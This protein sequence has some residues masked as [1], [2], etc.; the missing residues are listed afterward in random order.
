MSV[1]RTGAI[2]GALKFDVSEFRRAHTDVGEGARSMVTSLLGVGAKA[3]GAAIAIAI[4]TAA[5]AALAA[6]IK[7]AIK[8][9]M[10]FEDSF[11]F[12]RKTVNATAA[13]LDDM[14]KALQDMSL[15]V[16]LS[17]HELNT[18][19]GAAG[20]LGIAKENI[21]DFTRVMSEMGV[22]ADL[23]A[24]QSAVGFAQWANVT[25]LAT[26]K[27][28]NLTS[29][30]VL[31]GNTTATTESMVLNMGVRLAGASR[32][33][34]LADSDI[35][36][37]AATMSSLRIEAE[38]GGSAMSR[39]M[40]DMAEAVDSGGVNLELFAALAK[41]STTD[42]V[43]EFKNKPMQAITEFIGGLGR[44]EQ[45]GQNVTK[46]L[47][48]LGFVDVRVRSALLGMSGSADILADNVKRAAEEF[49]N[50]TARSDEAAKAFDRTSSKVTILSNSTGELMRSIGEGLQPVYE[51]LIDTLTDVV[52]KM[53]DVIDRDDSLR[54]LSALIF[55]PKATG[56]IRGYISELDA[57]SG[58]ADS[59]GKALKKVDPTI[60]KA[61][62]DHVNSANDAF[63]DQ[64]VLVDA[65]TGYFDKYKD[66]AEDVAAVMDKIASKS[67]KKS[68]GSSAAKELALLRRQATGLRL[69]LFPDEAMADAVGN[70]Q[71][72]AD[73]FPDI[74]D[75]DAVAQAMGK[76]WD[77]FKDKG[78]N[79]AE[80]FREHL[81]TAPV[82]FAQAMDLAIQK[83][84]TLAR[85]EEERA[86]QMREMERI[87]DLAGQSEQRG[88]DLFLALSPADGIAAQLS[89]DIEDLK[90]AGRL[91][92]ET[93]NLLAQDYWDEF[94]R[95][96]A[97]AVQDIIKSLG[98]I[99]DA[100]RNA[101]QGI[102][103]SASFDQTVTSITNVGQAALDAGSRLTKLATGGL[104]K[105]L[106][107][108]QNVVGAS[109]DMVARI[110]IMP[111]L[112]AKF[113][114][115]GISAAV[116]VGIALHI[117]LNVIALI[118]DAITIVM[119]LFG[120][121]GKEGVKDLKGMAKVIDEIKEASEA[122]IDSLT[123]KFVEFIHTGEL[124][125][126]SFVDQILDDIL[127]ISIRELV[128]SPAVGLVG[129]L[130]GLA[131]GGAFSKGH[132]VNS[133]EIFSTKS[134]PAVRGEAGTEVVMPAVR[135]SDGT[136]GVKGA[137]GGSVV[138]VYDQR[139]GDAPPV[140]VQ[141]RRGSNGED[142]IDIVIRAVERGLV[143]GDLDQ[144]LQL[145]APRL[146]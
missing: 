9:S 91:E 78:V 24:E 20:Q 59:A 146:R 68:G 19:A 80:V 125:W 18:I 53:D 76:V 43:N 127:R 86:E 65:N 145:I 119:D 35:A 110:R 52:Q 69:D 12:V 93:N 144:A 56:N 97:A 29:A 100:T 79:A 141:R 128:V 47:E 87:G 104:S 50:G 67:G 15:A 83:T 48:Q 106:A 38:A 82:E 140:D 116:K 64:A 55:G 34:G 120:A 26:E 58:G 21:L 45:S 103:K 139:T 7:K 121:W 1:F 23:T 134:G 51:S 136:L 6:A 41:R 70:I 33:L 30:V 129:D 22:A 63:K 36:A 92:G 94:S 130:F 89:Q 75:S 132:V 118:A 32:I 61:L 85:I 2:K 137:G 42:F 133:P 74:I 98:D 95:L 31:L 13:E 109:L 49:E 115:A 101:L 62:E 40:F 107:T 84:E 123:D 54:T 44:V 131:D 112:F 108:M 73:H 77:D 113:A 138:N 143:Q 96:P 8:A 117:A 71:E 90:N 57:L 88:N 72:L 105:V 124:N 99:P 126:K 25:G 4:V 60:A 28:D 39:V 10:A 14:A 5:V 27:I 11:S 102:A 46:V 111:E 114:T 16:P 135:L 66:T 3:T 122:W 17:V 81:A 37:L 142:I